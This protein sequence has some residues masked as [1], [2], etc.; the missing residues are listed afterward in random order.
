LYNRISEVKEVTSVREVNELLPL[1][2]RVLAIAE[3]EAKE[4]SFVYCMGKSL[5]KM[6]R[7]LRHAR[8]LSPDSSAIQDNK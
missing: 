1:D 7:N 8:K 6:S 2:W 4:N 3:V 5:I